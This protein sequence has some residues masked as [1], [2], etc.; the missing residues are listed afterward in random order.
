MNGF[1]AVSSGVAGERRTPF[2]PDQSRLRRVPRFVII[3]NA[4]IASEIVRFTVTRTL[5]YTT[6]AVDPIGR[7]S[8]E[9]KSRRLYERV[10]PSNVR[11]RA[12]SFY[13]AGDQSSQV[14][15]ENAVPMDAAKYT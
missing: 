15:V 1:F 12:H 11:T 7:Y 13:N 14:F 10:P 6:H 9:R 2:L 4:K 5:L 3:P 8:A